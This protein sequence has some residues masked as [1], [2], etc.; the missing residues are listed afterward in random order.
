MEESSIDTYFRAGVGACLQNENGEV[1]V[2]RRADVAGES[3]QM[4]Q[5]GI[6][7]GETPEQ[8]LIREVLEET[9]IDADRYELQASTGW[10][11]YELPEAY[12][13]TKTGRGQTQKWF[14]CRVKAGTEIRPDQNEF[15]SYRWV[16]PDQL[17]P[18]ASDFRR[19]A[20]R[21]IVYAL[22]L[23]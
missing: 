6:Q 4:P 2:M 12:W 18:L 7:N 22:G 16:R 8:A 23:T 19:D 3:W 1:L 20:Y 17:I 15:D 11:A 14:R 13:S 10:I 5:G 21:A 9:G